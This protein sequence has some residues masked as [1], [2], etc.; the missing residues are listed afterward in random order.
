MEEV[1]TWLKEKQKKILPDFEPHLNKL[2]KMIPKED[3]VKIVPLEKPATK[4][5]PIPRIG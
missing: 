5:V 4:M 3:L 1:A 2:Y